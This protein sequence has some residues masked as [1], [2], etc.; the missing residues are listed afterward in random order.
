MH[1]SST[2]R[3]SATQ[4]LLQAPPAPGETIYRGQASKNKGPAR[5]RSDF[6]QE[7]ASTDRR[8]FRDRDRHSS[9]SIA[10][11]SIGR[12]IQRQKDARVRECVRK[13]QAGSPSGANGPFAPGAA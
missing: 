2:A 4:E 3:P 1:P 9:E 13:W 5:A 6:R 7:E 12:E 8:E 11:R 10:K